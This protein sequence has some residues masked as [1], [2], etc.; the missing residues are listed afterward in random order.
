MDPERG[1]LGV[2][3]A[4]RS[5]ASATRGQSSSLLKAEQALPLGLPP[6]GAQPLESLIFPRPHLT[7]RRSHVEL[8]EEYLPPLAG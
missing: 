5:H 4:F 1:H 3:V 7:F 8:R 2:G 6:T